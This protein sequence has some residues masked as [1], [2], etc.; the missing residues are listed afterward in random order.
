MELKKLLII[1]ILILLI[2]SLFL[3]WKFNYPSD[4]TIGREIKKLNPNAEV[5]SS[6][7]IFD[8]EPKRVVT[9]IVKY[10]E[11]PSNE[12]LLYDFSLKQNWNFQWQWCS[13]QTERK[14]D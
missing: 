2:S 13:D 12:I 4:E 1:P 10:K 8:W 11:P 9:Y 7:M 3:Y 14:C 6:E 5:I